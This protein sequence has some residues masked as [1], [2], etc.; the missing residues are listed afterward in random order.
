GEGIDDLAHLDVHAL[1]GH[2]GHAVL[3]D[4]ARDDVLEVPQVGCDVEGHAVEGAAPL[5]AHADGGDLAGRGR[6]R[7]DPDPRVAVVAAG[8]GQPERGEHLDEDLLEGRHVR[9]GVGRTA[10]RALRREGDDRVRDQLPG[11]VVGDVAAAV[12]LDQ[13]DAVLGRVAEHVRAVRV[14]AEGVGGRV[15]EQQQPVVTGPRS[16]RV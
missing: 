7:V 6:V 4:A 13:V 5:D 10:G 1:R 14:A 11:A 15:L 2:R 16:V 3:A 12:D 8:A 9:R